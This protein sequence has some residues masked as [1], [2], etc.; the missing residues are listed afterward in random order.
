M[1]MGPVL[2]FLVKAQEVSQTQRQMGL[3]QPHCVL[4]PSQYKR[5]IILSRYLTGLQI[6]GN[7]D[8]FGPGTQ[9]QKKGNP[10]DATWTDDTRTRCLLPQLLLCL[11]NAWPQI[12]TLE[13]IQNPGLINFKILS[14]ERLGLEREIFLSSNKYNSKGLYSAY[15]VPDTILSTLTIMI[16]DSHNHIGSYYLFLC[17]IS[18]K[19]EAQRGLEFC[20]MLHSQ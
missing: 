10:E 3:R 15:C 4:I 18:D 19:S 11:P 9:N 7:I 20:P 16:K 8:L 1:Q 17:F 14:T 12:S 2:L 13:L 5:H 6:V